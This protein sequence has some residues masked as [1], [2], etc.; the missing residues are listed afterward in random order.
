M[1]FA[2]LNWRKWGVVVAIHA[3][4]GPLAVV[5]SDGRLHEAVY[6]YWQ[7]PLFLVVIASL[8]RFAWWG[9]HQRSVEVLLITIGVLLAT[10][11]AANDYAT[12]SGIFAHTRVYTLHLA[13]PV[14]LL[15]IGALL[16]IRFLRALRSSEEANLVLAQRLASKEHEL[17]IHFD[18]MRQLE[19]RKAS[20][21]ERQRIMQDM[22]DGLGAQLVSS[23]V[24]VEQG[25]AQ[26]SDIATLLRESL[27]EMRLA[28]DAFG[29]AEI[30]LNGAL[31]SLRYRMEP[32][33][34]AAGMTLCWSMDESFTALQP[35][36]HM[37]LQLLRIVQE[38]L[39]NVI[40]HSRA[41]ELSVGFEADDRYL[42]ITVSD[43]GAGFQGG[44][45]NAGHGLSGIRKRAHGIR[46]EADIE[47]SARGTTV[48]VRCPVPRHG[49]GIGDDI[50]A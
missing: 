50:A 6:T 32:R 25:G 17:A 28:I 16:T 19:Q 24:M 26:P 11:L 10:A 21:A 1:S 5:A 8:V 13:L 46:G 7:G 41:T 3:V 37:A 33:L 38:A 15:T 42:R 9:Y 29:Q 27:D 23:L 34:R 40:K 31:A 12:V 49:A 14:L 36:E 20:A 44:Y 30:D 43:N 2:G 4:A 39:S 45:A 35:D 48:V 47:T 18:R 22:H